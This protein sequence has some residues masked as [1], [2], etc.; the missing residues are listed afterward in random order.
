MNCKQCQQYMTESLAAAEQ[1]LA[2]EVAVH[3]RSCAVC[4]EFYLAQQTLFRLTDAGLRSLAN[5]PVPPSLLPGVRARLDEQPLPHL[6]WVARWGLAVPAVL[7]ILI[8]S[9]SHI[10]H[11][12]AIRPTVAANV[13]TASRNTDNPEPALEPAQ[14]PAT[15]FPLP[16]PKRVRRTPSSTAAWEVIVLP[17]ERLAFARFV[18]EIPKERNVALALTRPAPAAAEYSTEIALLKIDNLVVKPLEPTAEE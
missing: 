9:A 2:P 17:E 18:A 6:A 11:Q 7:A 5:Q 12:R 4:G 3:Q 15:V 10:L 1:N 13:P 8:L 14:R 16:K